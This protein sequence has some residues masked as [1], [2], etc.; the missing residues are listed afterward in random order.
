MSNSTTNCV[1]YSKQTD[2]E[3]IA[4]PSVR[5]P[6]ISAAHTKQGHV[7]DLDVNTDPQTR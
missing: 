2:T 6:S 4:Q 7:L 5:V 3:T 1:D